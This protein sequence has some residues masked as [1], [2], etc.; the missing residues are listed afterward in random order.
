MSLGCL[1]AEARHLNGGF[2][3]RIC[4]GRP[5]A[6]LKLAASADGRI[7]TAS[8]DSMWIT[9]AAA[10][11]EG[12]RLRL[13]HDAILVGSGTA[14]ADDP[15]LTCR[16]PGLAQRSPVR[17]VVDRRLRLAPTS[18]L[19]RSAG[20]PPV[21]LLTS[22]PDD[23]AAVALAAAGVLVL[24]LPEA[25]A[26]PA[27]VLAT[28]AERGITRVLIEGGAAIAAA[29]LRDR[30]VDRLYWFGAPVLLGAEGTP[31]V[32]A[33]GLARLRDARRWRC[34]AEQRLEPDRLAVLE[35]VDPAS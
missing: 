1:E 2:L 3:R 8:G 16:L 32:G 17:V 21:W 10:R 29:F 13:R 18:R 31:A 4:A 25:A 7:A 9:G 35:P 22:R 34:V 28:L 6:A 33:L 11:A 19:A 5:L 27:Q 15:T 26:G 12:H 23:P 14:L 24:P 20:A 30:L